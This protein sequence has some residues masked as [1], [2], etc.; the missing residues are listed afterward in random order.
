MGGQQARNYRVVLTAGGLALKKVLIYGT[1]R[2]ANLLY[3]Y[4]KDDVDIMGFVETRK[5]SDSFNNLP[6]YG[7]DEVSGTGFDEIYI[8][9]TH[10]ETISALLD[11][12]IPKSK[13]SLCAEIY[14]EYIERNHGVPDIRCASPVVM[15]RV[16]EATGDKN[17]ELYG[18]EAVYSVDYCRH[19]TLELLAREIKTNGVGGDVA[20]LGV[21]RGNFAAR[22]NRAF[23]DR[24]LFLFDTFE[25]F[26]KEELTAEMGK[27]YFED[28]VIGNDDFKN[29]SVDF[30]LAKMPCSE[31]CVV[32]K[33]WFPSTV[34]EEDLSYAFVSIDCDLYTPTISG[35]EYFYPR[36]LSGGYI[37]LH[38]YNGKDF[39]RGVKQAV[40]DYEE[41]NGRL[42]KIPIPDCNGTLIIGK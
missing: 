19:E 33:G 35:L 42:V 36:V 28:G 32:R 37:M 38:D 26:D 27:G 7:V 16:L 11:L 15:T 30:V 1:K 13:L 5:T 6:V 29:T 40:K 9:N 10:L 12:G 3:H 2:I 39:G 22:I 34:P 24:R 14:P 25:G 4:L 23:P 41:K 31:M 17:V 20:E 8:A 21:N 18:T